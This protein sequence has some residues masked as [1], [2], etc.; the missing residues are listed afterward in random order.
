MLA[1]LRL[2]RSSYGK[3]CHLVLDIEKITVLANVA[4]LKFAI[5]DTL[6]GIMKQFD[7]SPIFSLLVFII[8]IAAGCAEVQK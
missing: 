7:L 3:A 1:I 2:K 4:L 6:G 5:S 8:L